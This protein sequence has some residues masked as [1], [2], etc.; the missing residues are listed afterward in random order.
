ME[1]VFKTIKGFDNYEISNLGN[2]KNAKTGK[3]MK[4]E[5]SKK[6][7]YFQANLMNVS[8]KQKH[9]KIHI[10]IAQAF[11]PNPQNK[12]CV[13]HIDKDRTNN[14]LKNL[15]WATY[16]E[17]GMNKCKLNANTSGYSG[18]FYRKDTKKWQSRLTIDRKTYSKSFK[19]K[20]EAIEYRAELERI[21]FG[22]YSANYK[23]PT[24]INNITN[25]ITIQ[26][27]Q[28]FNNNPIGKT[29]EQLELD[30]LEK[31]LERQFEAA[32]K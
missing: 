24:I 15:R 30:E 9:K 32:M 22:I 3:I 29:Q 31:E 14:N 20:E 18:V 16:S 25:N 2:V 13:D 19:T 27:V 12:P 4:Q 10:L 8:G 1:E 11:I 6:A 21:H 23:P 5:L 7:G 26:T 28:T 17:N